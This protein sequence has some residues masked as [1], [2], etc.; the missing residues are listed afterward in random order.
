MRR[1]LLGLLAVAILLVVADRLTAALAG[2]LV[3]EQ[4][5]TS[6]E[7]PDRPDVTLEG[8]PFLTQ[9]VGGRYRT[10]HVVATD[11]PAGDTT[12]A[13]LTADL[14]G[15]HVP[16]SDVVGRSV[17]SVPV[18]RIDARV[19]LSYGELSRRSGPRALTVS[20]A[21]DR[22]RVRGSVQVLGRTIAVAALSDVTVEGE[23]I[24]VTARS[25]EAGSGVADAVLSKALGGRLDLRVA[26]RS[27]PY[28]L[29]IRQ[30][31]V[32]PQGL[33]LEAVSTGAVLS[34]G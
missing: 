14:R 31:S 28:G 6:A 8:F 16:L 32:G 20:A 11:L 27:L 33:T 15:V 23:Q 1:L 2:R 9:A 5:Q 29:R 7:L 12:V 26:V 25:Y 24:V 17:G 21:G 30:L 3:A 34:A 22:L 4:L 19:L 10:V 13:R 18:D